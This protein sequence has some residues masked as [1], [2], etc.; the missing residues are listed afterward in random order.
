MHHHQV[1]ISICSTVSF[2]VKPIN[3]YSALIK[4]HSIVR[5]CRST[6]AT[7]SNE[8]LHL[9]LNMKLLIRINI[10]LKFPAAVGVY[11]RKTCVGVK[12]GLSL[13]LRYF[14]R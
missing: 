3:G 11:G 2:T 12:S 10:N 14:G 7:Y 9:L 4:H 6:A 8:T 1:R 5:G 13:S